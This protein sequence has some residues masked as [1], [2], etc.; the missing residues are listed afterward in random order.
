MRWQ[1]TLKQIDR[2]KNRSK[3]LMQPGLES[4]QARV[5]TLE[6]GFG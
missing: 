4:E 5:G 2:V 3:L 6:I 1:V